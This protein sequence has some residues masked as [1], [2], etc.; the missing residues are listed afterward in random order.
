MFHLV[1]RNGGALTAE[2]HMSCFLKL[3]FMI[4]IDRTK[5]MNMVC[6]L[7]ILPDKYI[8]HLKSPMN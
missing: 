5:M 1:G 4:T 3:L 8:H 2:I 6:G 7:G